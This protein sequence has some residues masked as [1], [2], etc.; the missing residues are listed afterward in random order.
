MAMD[1]LKAFL[2]VFGKILLLIG[3]FI[4]IGLLTDLYNNQNNLHEWN[5]L[6]PAMVGIVIGL[7]AFAIW[8]TY[9]L[10]RGSR[11]IREQ[12][13]LDGYLHIIIAW[14]VI[15]GIFILVKYTIL[16]DENEVEVQ[17]SESMYQI[18]A[19]CSS[20]FI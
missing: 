12:R 15:I 2:R 8:S 14:A 3:I 4:L 19:Y 5:A 9:M 17:Q 6:V 11:Y 16:D 20:P 1:I 10:I 7:L 18:D 13:K